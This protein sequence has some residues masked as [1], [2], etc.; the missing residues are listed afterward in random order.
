MKNE[1]SL[2]MNRERPFFLVEE[3]DGIKLKAKKRHNRP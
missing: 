3:G 2:G 1:K